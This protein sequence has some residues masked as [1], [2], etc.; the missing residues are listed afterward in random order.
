MPILDPTLAFVIAHYNPD[1]KVPRD[2]FNLVAYISK[3]SDRIVFVSTN[4]AESEINKLSPYAHVIARENF[5]Y[6][7][8]S[9]KLGLQTLGNLRQTERI[10][11]F[12]SSFITFDPEILMNGFLKP[13]S[14]QAL[15]G[16][17][18]SSYPQFHVQS[19]LFAFETSALINSTEF[20][21][22]WEQMVPLSN[23][24]EVID[25]YEIGMSDW[26]SKRGV[27]I[28]ST[29]IIGREYIMK[30]IYYALVKRK[31]KISDIAK[32]LR[33]KLHSYVKMHQNFN[34]THFLWMPLYNQCKIF[35]IDLIK[36]NPT[37]QDLNKLF[38]HIDQDELELIKDAIDVNWLLK[39][40]ER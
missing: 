10:V 14:G 9:Y 11:F 19:Y 13:V 28:K 1:G 26:F 7:F 32:L 20:K 27:P 30:S 34:P 6:D 31:W 8:W 24:D 37:N 21:N 18:V 4:I 22:W 33:M 35:K 23:R 29:L 5:G 3:V 39:Y 17:T 16:L 36:N 2:L 25:H 38:Q 40:T 15:R 12:N